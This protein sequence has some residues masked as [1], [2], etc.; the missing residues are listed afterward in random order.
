MTVRKKPQ[1]EI[2][3]EEEA[4]AVVLRP[5]F[6]AQ[7]WESPALRRALLQEAVAEEVGRHIGLR[8]L[9]GQAAI[10]ATGKVECPAV[11]DVC[12]IA[13]PQR[14]RSGY[15]RLR[16]CLGPKIS[17]RCG[18]IIARDVSSHERN[19]LQGH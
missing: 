15:Q 5:I 18:R 2:Q 1:E 3:V 13:A 7:P 17:K 10:R 14:R 16:C 11:G 12:T 9:T 19:R 4:Q 8:R 6:S